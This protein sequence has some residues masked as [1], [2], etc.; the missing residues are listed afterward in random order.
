MRCRAAAAEGDATAAAADGD[1]DG[2]AAGDA[3]DLATCEAA[4]TARHRRKLRGGRLG[5]WGGQIPIAAALRPKRGARYAKSIQALFSPVTRLIT[6][7]SGVN[8]KSLD[9]GHALR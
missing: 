2:A 6:L 7:C 3:D 1:T 5:P 8:V 4:L 9:R